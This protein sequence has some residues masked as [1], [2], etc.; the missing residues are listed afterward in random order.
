[1]KEIDNNLVMSYRRNKKTNFQILSYFTLIRKTSLKSKEWI[2]DWKI[3]F[4]Y[5]ITTLKWFNTRWTN[6]SHICM[7]Q[8]L[9]IL[10]YHIV[11][12]FRKIE[13]ISK[14]FLKLKLFFLFFSFCSHLHFI[15]F[16]CQMFEQEVKKWMDNIRK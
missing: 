1:M 11:L 13:L 7:V 8:Y 4:K 12:R 6:L 10:D 3:K 2:I 5:M 15:A 14:G 16:Y 9:E